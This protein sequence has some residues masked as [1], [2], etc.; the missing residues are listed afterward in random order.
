MPAA[1]TPQPTRPSSTK[2][3]LNVGYSAAKDV[4]MILDPYLPASARTAVCYAEAQAISAT[5]YASKQAEFAT[6]QAVDI[7]NKTFETTHQ[8]LEKSGA[9]VVAGQIEQTR[10]NTQNTA[11]RVVEGVKQRG[12]TRASALFLGD[13]ILIRS[14]TA[15]KRY[16]DTWSLAHKVAFGAADIVLSYAPKTA[17]DLVKSALESVDA[18]RVEGVQALKGRVPDFVVNGATQSYEIFDHTL[19]TLQEK[20]EATISSINH[21]Y[22]ETTGYIVSRVNGTVEYVVAKLP[23]GN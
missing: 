23:P 9:L 5:E 8:I 4:A 15:W 3:L 14:L 6:K 1:V 10:V 13:E 16:N 12:E 22:T 11:V 17:V 2:A 7:K 20:K 19:H 18:V 21:T